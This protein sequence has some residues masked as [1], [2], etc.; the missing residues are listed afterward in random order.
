MPKRKEPSP[1]DSK[2]RSVE[3]RCVDSLRPHPRQNELFPDLPEHEFQALVEDIRKN[4]IRNPPEILPDG[5]ILAGHQ[6]LRAARELGWEEINVVVRDDLR[7]ADEATIF[8]EFVY[9]NLLRRHLTKLHQAKCA[10]ELARGECER[11]DFIFDWQRE[12]LI[13]TSV[14]ERLAWCKKNAA[15][16]IHVSQTPLPI[17]EAFDRKLLKLVDAAGIANLPKENQE[18]LA[19]SVSKLLREA[20]AKGTKSIKKKIGALVQAAFQKSRR[21]KRVPARSPIDTL[22][23][24]KEF[25]D[26]YLPVLQG[27]KTAIISDL[28]GDDLSV[29]LRASPA[30]PDLYR[31]RSRI[32][33]EVQETGNSLLGELADISNAIEPGA[34][35]SG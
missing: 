3:K 2:P 20:E 26:D 34:D 7:D 35:A 17:Q 11:R 29:A 4:G 8:E 21:P 28:R 23:K 19:A 27:N 30:F 1:S 12:K 33:Q 10:I 32:V 22:R 18:R 14:M 16:Y 9:D 24:L 25:L 5:T 15:R 31:F 13:L 6:R